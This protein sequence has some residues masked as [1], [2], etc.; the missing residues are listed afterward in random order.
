MADVNSPR[1]YAS[2]MREKAA[3][4][5]RI[6]ILTAAEQLFVEQGYVATTVDQIARRAGVA[7]P[8]VFAAGGN[9]ASLLTAI[10]DRALAG[11]DEPVPV[12]RREWYREALDEPDPRRSLRLHAR[13]VVRV[14]RRYAD[15]EAVL[16]AAAAADSDLAQLWRSNEDERRQGA[17]F[18]IDALLRKSPIRSELT[19]DDAVDL[20]W[21]FTASDHYRRLVGD[22]GWSPERY[23]RWLADTFC[24]QLLPQEQVSSSE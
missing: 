10:R 21:T 2:P 7:R 23:E 15:I 17:E 11:D 3:Q 18:V 5:T 22:R 8:T 13:N 1:S 20:M 19:R 14:S 12:A 4:H 6:A 24:A 16:G 9:K